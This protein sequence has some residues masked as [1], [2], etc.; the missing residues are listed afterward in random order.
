LLKEINIEQVLRSKYQIIH[1]VMI[2]LFR[3]ARYIED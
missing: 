3:K 1:T 2:I